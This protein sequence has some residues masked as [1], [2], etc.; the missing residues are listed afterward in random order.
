MELKKNKMNIYI[1][2]NVTVVREYFDIHVFDNLR[3]FSNS[4]KII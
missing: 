3:Q 4:M 2:N 1:M